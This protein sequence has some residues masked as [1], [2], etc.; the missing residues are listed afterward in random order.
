[1]VQ[2]I[3]TYGTVAV[4]AGY[5]LYNLINIIRTAKKKDLYCSGCGGG[6]DHKKPVV[7]RQINRTL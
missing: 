6:C 3:L 5:T 1:M 2:N 7:L 4:A